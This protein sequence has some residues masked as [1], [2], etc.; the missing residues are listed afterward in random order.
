VSAGGRV[1]DNAFSPAVAACLVWSSFVLLRLWQV[2]AGDI[3]AFVVA[4]TEWTDASSGLPLTDGAGYDGQFFHRFAS[5]PFAIGERVAG[6]VL[7]SPARLNRFGYPLLAWI[8]GFTGLPADWALVIVNLVAVTLLGLL[9]GLIARRSGRHALWGVVLPLYFGFT[10]TIARDLAEVVAATALVGGLWGAH[11]GRYALGA[12]SL[13]LAVLTRETVIVAVFAIGLVELWALARRQRPIGARDAIWIAPGAVVFIWQVTARD[14]WGATPLLAGGTGTVRPPGAAFA[15]QFPTLIDTDWLG[16][17]WLHAVHAFEVV[18][19][20]GVVLWALVSVR[21]V[22]RSSPVVPA[23]IGLVAGASIVD[24]PEG[25]WIDR[26]DLRMFVD[27]YAVSMMVL[28]MVK[29][30]LTV[31]AVAVATCT[32]LAGLSFLAG[33]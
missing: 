12:M 16:A 18:V 14:R 20:L 27:L 32:A 1:P 2:G 7:D 19:L 13:S 8:A 31:P 5:D 23:L 6:T 24:V 9:G 3:G 15:E 28:I 29:A 33:A 21:R 4:G 22:D 25:I 10:F 17:D 30:R 26:N 11:R